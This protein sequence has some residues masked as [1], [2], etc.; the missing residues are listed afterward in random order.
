MCWNIYIYKI[1]KYS[2]KRKATFKHILNWVMV[3]S[4]GSRSLSAQLHTSCD[5]NLGFILFKVC[6]YF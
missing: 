3:I 2:L 5:Y 1:C 4:T 6:M